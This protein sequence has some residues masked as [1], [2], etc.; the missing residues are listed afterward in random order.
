MKSIRPLGAFLFSFAMPALL[1]A[2]TAFAQRIPWQTSH[3]QGTPEP[4]LPYVAERVFPDL[5][6]KNPL[7]LTFIPGTSLI[8]VA[9]QKGL[10]FTFPC[11]SEKPEIKPFAD[12]HAYDPEIVETYALT[13]HPRFQENRFVYIWANLNSKGQ[14]NRENG[15]KII[16]FKVTSSPVPSIDLS[17]GT[18]LFSWLSGG[19]NG[20]NLRFGP[21]GMLYIATGDA[22]PPDPPDARKTGQDIS[23]VLSSILRIDVDHPD[24]KHPYT[25]PKDNPFVSTPDARG[26]VWAYGLRNPWRMSFNPKNGDLFVGDV[27]WELWE[28]IYR[29]KPGGNYGWSLTEGSRQDVR[30]ERPQGPT[31]VVPPLVAH[32]HEEAASITGGEFYHGTKN[33]ELKGAYIYGDWQMGTFWSLRTEGDRVLEKRELCRSSLMPAGFGIGPD[34]ELFIC[35][36]SGGGI[37]QLRANPLFGKPTNFP[38]KL[39]QTGLFTNTSAQAPAPGVFP[40]SVNAPRWADHATSERWAAVP[41]TSGAAVSDVSK[42]VL[43]RGQW[44]FPDGSVFAKTYS[45]EMER[46]N[47]ATKRRIETQILHFDGNLWA[48]YS[49]RW[50]AE[51]TDADLV[52]L[53]GDEATLTIKDKNSPDGHIQ[54][55]W[56]FFSRAECAR[57]HSMWNNFAPGFNTLQ[58]DRITETAPGRQTDVLAKLGLIPPEPRMTDPHGTIGTLE[59]RARS[60]LHANCGTCHRY[61]GGGAVPIYLN[62]EALP[63]DTNILDIRPIQGDLGLPDARLVARG[64]AARSVLLF[65]MATAGRGHM[66]YLGGRSVDERGLLL[67]RD[68]IEG[69][70]GSFKDIS[71]EAAVQR[72]AEREAL[73][74]LKSGDLAP[75]DSLLQTSSGCLSILLSIVD[76]TLPEAV[77]NQAVAKGGKLSEPLHRDLFERFLPESERRKVLGTAFNPEIILRRTGDSQRGQKLFAGLCT[78]CHKASGAGG[79]FGPALDHIGSKWNREALL[80]QILYP[81]KFIDPEWKL[82]TVELKSGVSKTGFMGAMDKPFT[83]LKQMGGIQEKIPTDQIMMIAAAKV[84]AMP[85]GLLQGLTAQEA[86][87]LL[88]Y[89]GSH[90]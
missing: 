31:P 58:L 25:I 67:I 3:I 19:H 87:D 62:I 54:E 44:G 60:Y 15:S 43:M 16:R 84:S 78:A 86:A 6:F 51:Q 28:M 68:W 5:T 18:P 80:E 53:R 17:S 32:S 85:E 46:G 20:G 21:D 37:W 23:D 10:L 82:T 61:N 7:D 38:L 56:R 47:P 22:S 48:N 39:S 40:Y 36:H 57:C 79:D 2:T 27:G 14:R 69:L 26:E 52:P 81:S 63:K 83:V 76:K 74:K 50:N 64:D 75:L 8:V 34:Q 88:E 77:R 33:P 66:P 41:G 9:E 49:Y 24:G 1:L 42:G 89:L 12:L 35:D 90:K 55:Q 71:Q 70:K 59:V 30:P 72:D 65:R 11:T 13:F 45:L 4:P 73:D 29:I